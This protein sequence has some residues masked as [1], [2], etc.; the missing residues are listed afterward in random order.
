MANEFGMNT[1]KYFPMQSVV[2]LWNLQLREAIESNAVGG[3]HK[4]L[5][6]QTAA[7]AMQIVLWKLRT[8]QAFTV[9]ARKRVSGT[10]G[11]TGAAAIFTK[12]PLFL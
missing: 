8:G 12:E 9:V 11:T 4:E 7:W 1:K 2:D 5:V 6:W 3:F 10:A